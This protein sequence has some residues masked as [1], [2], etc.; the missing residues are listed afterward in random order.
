MA[1]LVPKYIYVK[2]HTNVFKL[3]QILRIYQDLTENGQKQK[4]EMKSSNS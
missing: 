3:N 1:L 2:F 4:N